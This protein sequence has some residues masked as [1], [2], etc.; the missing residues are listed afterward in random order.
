ML[1]FAVSLLLHV[2][3]PL[4]FI[5]TVVKFLSYQTI[6]VSQTKKPRRLVVNIRGGDICSGDYRL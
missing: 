3:A 5:C 2:H 6:S 1:R 4:K